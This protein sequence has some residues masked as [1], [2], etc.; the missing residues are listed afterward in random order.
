MSKPSSTHAGTV[1]LNTSR[2]ISS[3]FA[4]LHHSR[5]GQEFTSTAIHV[6]LVA[7]ADGKNG[8]QWP[9][10]ALASVGLPSLSRKIGIRCQ[11]FAMAPVGDRYRHFSA[12][13]SACANAARQPMSC[14]CGSRSAAGT[15]HPALE[16]H[17]VR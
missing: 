12:P 3:T 14:P 10:K 8:A 4:A 5:I 17:N 6:N 1:W 7:R 2:P 15:L 11:A 9:S 13:K 16:A